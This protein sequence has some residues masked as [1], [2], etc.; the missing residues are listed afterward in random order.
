MLHSKSQTSKIRADFIDLC[1]FRDQSDI[2]TASDSESLIEKVSLLHDILKG[3]NNR[4][5]RRSKPRRFKTLRT[6][7]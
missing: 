5:F 6:A 7:K 3:G 2:V 1:N 4:F